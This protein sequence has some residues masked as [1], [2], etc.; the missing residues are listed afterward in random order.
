MAADTC[1]LCGQPCGGRDSSGDE[2]VCA[3]CAAE[4]TALAVAQLETI[5]VPAAAGTHLYGEYL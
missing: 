3:C 4:A 2:T 1:T 5:P